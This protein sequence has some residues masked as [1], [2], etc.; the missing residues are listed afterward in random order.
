MHVPLV[1]CPVFVFIE[2]PFRHAVRE[3]RTQP[4]I[5]GMA[6]SAS[7]TRIRRAS[8]I[9]KLGPHQTVGVVRVRPHRIRFHSTVVLSNVTE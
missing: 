2:N 1:D 7:F 8:A 6:A 3:R 4:N 5:P 9:G